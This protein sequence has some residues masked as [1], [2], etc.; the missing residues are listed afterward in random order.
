MD[1]F[2]EAI[3]LATYARAEIDQ[4][5]KWAI[6]AEQPFTLASCTHAVTQRMDDREAGAWYAA[7]AFAWTDEDEVVA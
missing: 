7:L 1:I 2:S 6:A 4:G 5:R 3:S